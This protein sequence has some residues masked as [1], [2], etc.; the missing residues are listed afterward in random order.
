MPE[1]TQEQRKA[2]SM[3]K[4]HVDELIG[5]DMVR[6]TK[7]W[8]NS[9]EDSALTLNFAVTLTGI[10]EVEVETKIRYTVEQVRDRVKDTVSAQLPLPV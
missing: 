8:Q 1:L 10:H 9:G 6:I 2:L 3:I 5:T 7:A 4:T